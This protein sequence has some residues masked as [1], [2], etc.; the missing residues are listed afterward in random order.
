[1]GNKIDLKHRKMLLTGLRDIAESLGIDTSLA[2]V[3]P[4]DIIEDKNGHPIKRVV[5]K[6]SFVRPKSGIEKAC[7]FL[8]MEYKT[9]PYASGDYFRQQYNLFDI[10]KRSAHSKL[11][12]EVIV[13]CREYSIKLREYASDYEVSKTLIETLNRKLNSMIVPSNMFV[14]TDE[15]IAKEK[16]SV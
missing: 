12:R 1:M 16:L 6:K 4:K 15:Y 11:E 5:K 9:C 13:T 7:E 8:G 3:D 14:N 2:D 10:V